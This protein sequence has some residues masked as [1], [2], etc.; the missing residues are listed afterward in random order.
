MLTGHALVVALLENTKL[1]TL[2]LAK[3]AIAYDHMK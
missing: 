2:L 3:N 1:V